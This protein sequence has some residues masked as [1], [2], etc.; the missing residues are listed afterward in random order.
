MTA[1]TYQS[2]TERVKVW[3]DEDDS[4]LQIQFNNPERHNAPPLLLQRAYL[5]TE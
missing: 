3:L 1:V 2:S 5:Q 4:T